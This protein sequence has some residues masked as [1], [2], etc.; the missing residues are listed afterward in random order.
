MAILSIILNF[1]KIFIRINTKKS[2]KL[3][4]YKDIM[5]NNVS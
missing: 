3:Y 5:L 1:N 4:I 2:D